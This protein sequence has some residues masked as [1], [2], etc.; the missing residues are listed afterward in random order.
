MPINR[1]IKKILYIY[2][3]KYYSALN[4]EITPCAATWKGLEMI[5]LCN[6]FQRKTKS[7]AESNL[8]NDTNELIYKTETDLQ[9][10]KTHGYQR[11]HVSVGINQ[12]LGMNTH[13][14]I[15]KTDIKQLSSN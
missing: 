6:I 15:Y 7:Y 10:W 9:V 12:E 8:N 4:N 11:G 1:G 13:T 5:I 14:T 2:R 3:M